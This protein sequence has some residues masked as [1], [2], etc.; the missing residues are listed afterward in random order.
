MFNLL[1]TA[2]VIIL[3][4]APAASA[5]TDRK[6]VSGLVCQPENP[7]DRANLHYFARG[8]HARNKAVLINCPIT[9]DSTLSGLK[10]FQARYQRGFEPPPQGQS[11]DQFVGEFTGTLFS[12]S[13]KERGNPC[14]GINV[15][16]DRSNDPTSAAATVIDLP[17]EDARYYV[18]KTL[19]RKNAILKSLYYI[20]KQ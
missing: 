11:G 7:E 9:R 8:V 10:F 12:C 1:A 13:D 16:S 14:V 15:R 6:I 18:F 4:T 3:V 20:K 2:A 19:L 5:Q 17:H